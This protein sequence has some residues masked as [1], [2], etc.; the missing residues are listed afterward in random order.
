MPALIQRH[1]N[2]LYWDSIAFSACHLCTQ[3]PLRLILLPALCDQR[4][5]DGVWLSGGGRGLAEVLHLPFLV[6]RASV[7]SLV[8]RLWASQLGRAFLPSVTSGCPCFPNPSQNPPL[9]ASNW[10]VHEWFG[11][12][13]FSPPPSLP[14]FLPSFSSSSLL[15]L[16]LPSPH[17][18]LSLSALLCFRRHAR[19]QR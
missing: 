19:I 16:P 6:H 3:Y 4:S 8:Q 17:F 18:S 15:L 14:F 12:A 1:S 13:G 10:P 9:L 11:L 7:L 2:N 5:P